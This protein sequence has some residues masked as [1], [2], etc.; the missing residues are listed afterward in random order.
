MMLVKEVLLCIRALE[1]MLV[2]KAELKSIA[3]DI[4]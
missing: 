4:L 1:G 2:H 3:T